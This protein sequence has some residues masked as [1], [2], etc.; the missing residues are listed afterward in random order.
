MH[1]HAGAVFFVF[2]LSAWFDVQSQYCQGG[3]GDHRSDRCDS[4]IHK[5][6]A[7]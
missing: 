7:Q 2:F 5:V 1:A 4:K 3:Y 6:E